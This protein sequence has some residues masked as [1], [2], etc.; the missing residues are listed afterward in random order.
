MGIY[1]DLACRRMWEQR[2]NAGSTGFAVSPVW[3]CAQHHLA[4]AWQVN[5]AAVRL[6]PA[7]LAIAQ[8]DYDRATKV[9]PAPK[10]AYTT[11][12]NGKWWKAQHGGAEKRKWASQDAWASTGQARPRTPPPAR[13]PRREW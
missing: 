10:A 9:A 3:P 8:N 7:V 1:Y 5:E 2:C 12:G 13:R 6:D 4:R 11:A